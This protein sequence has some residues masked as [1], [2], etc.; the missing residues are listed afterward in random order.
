MTPTDALLERIEACVTT[1]NAAPGKVWECNGESIVAD[2]QI[3]W[4]KVCSHP[5]CEIDY[6]NQDDFDPESCEFPESSELIAAAMIVGHNIAPTLL[7]DAAAEIK[8]L[9][10]RV[11]ELEEEASGKFEFGGFEW[12]YNPEEA[13]WCAYMDDPEYPSLP[14]C[15]VAAKRGDVFVSGVDGTY[16]CEPFPKTLRAAMTAA[17]EYAKGEGE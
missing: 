10:A 16:E 6:E 5:I 3:I 12:E 4:G 11:K 17:I 13:E 14:L 9:R 2:V 1:I 8:T 15:L 7:T